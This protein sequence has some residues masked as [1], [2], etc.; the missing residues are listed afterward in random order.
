MIHL[1]ALELNRTAD[2]LPASD[3]TAN[4][5][6]VHGPTPAPR[7]PDRSGLEHRRWHNAGGNGYAP[8]VL[9]RRSGLSPA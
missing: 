9:A 6:P 4:R 1:G 3:D 7:E 2:P 5:A 8:A